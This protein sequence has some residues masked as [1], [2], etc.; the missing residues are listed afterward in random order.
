MCFCVFWREIWWDKREKKAQNPLFSILVLS[1]CQGL[2]IALGMLPEA[3]WP[4][5]GCRVKSGRVGGHSKA[6]V[7][8]IMTSAN[9]SY[10]TFLVLTLDAHLEAFLDSV[11]YYGPI[12]MSSFQKVKEIK[13][14]TIGSKVM[15]SGSMLTRFSQLSQYLNRFNSDFDP[16]IVVRMRIWLSLQ[17]HLFQLILMTRSKLG[18]LGPIEIVNPESNL[19]KFAKI[20]RE[21]RVWYKTIKNVVLW[22]DFD[23]VWPLVNSGLTKGILVILA[24]KCT[25]SAP[26]SEQVAPR[27]YICS[28][29]PMERKWYFC[30]FQGLAR[31]SREDKIQYQQY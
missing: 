10:S 23:L 13:N 20:L 11:F 18:F 15:T 31:K 27:H 28:H 26:M 25:L 29:D 21:A 19:V 22:G 2:F 8:V 12:W 16:W 14:P 1:G 9:L 4:F 24:K 5:K 17:C 3:R 30:V 7:D 6:A